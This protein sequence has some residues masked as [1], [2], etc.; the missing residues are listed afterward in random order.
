MK[1]LRIS[2]LAIILPIVAAGLV[3]AVILLAA[4]QDMPASHLDG[5]QKAAEQPASGGGEALPSDNAS[6]KH[7]PIKPDH[8]VIAF[9]F[10][11]GYQSDYDLAYPILK[12]Y[13]INGTSYIIGK[14]PDGNIPDTLTWDEIRKMHANGWDFGCHTYAHIRLTTMTPDE[15]RQSMEMENA[16]FQRNG[17]PIPDIHAFPYGAYNQQVI[18]VIKEYR[19]Q[20]R[21][22]YYEE[23][24]VDLNHV[25]PYEIDS[26]SVDMHT[27]HLLEAKEKLVDKACAEDAVIVFRVHCMYKENRNDMGKWPVQTDSRLFAKLVDYCVSKGCRFITMDQLEQMYS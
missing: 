10:D 21:K 3:C 11:D 18:D 19:K 6:Q 13:G 27:A 1:K 7:K 22:A 4:P 2:P 15:I 5:N 23:K 14:Y 16:S 9:T 8:A 12:R 26:I 17:L 25:N 24:F 20:M